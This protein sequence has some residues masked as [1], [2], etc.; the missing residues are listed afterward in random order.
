MFSD[1]EIN[2]RNMEVRVCPFGSEIVLVRRPSRIAPCRVQSERQQLPRGYGFHAVDM[3]ISRN[4][5]KYNYQNPKES[6][7]R[8]LF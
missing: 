7:S 2:P 3:D 8:R 4:G 1:V 5:R 6:R